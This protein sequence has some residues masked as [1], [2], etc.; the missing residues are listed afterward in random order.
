VQVVGQAGAFGKDG[1]LVAGLLT[2]ER[3]TRTWKGRITGWI[4]TPEHAMT[5]ISGTLPLLYKL[6]Q[7]LA[8]EPLVNFRQ[9]A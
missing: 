3:F 7:A 9:P 5:K 2:F 6:S 1:F 8:P 4:L